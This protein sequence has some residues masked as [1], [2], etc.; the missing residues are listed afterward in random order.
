[1]ISWTAGV[2]AGSFAVEVVFVVV[3]DIVVVEMWVVDVEG[4]GDDD[5]GLESTFFFVSRS[6]SSKRST[7]ITKNVSQI[8]FVQVA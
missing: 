3:V 7:F 6:A 5:T 1:L 8:T 4:D 2:G